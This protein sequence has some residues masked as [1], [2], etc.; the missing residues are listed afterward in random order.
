MG[1]YLEQATLLE[2]E[3]FIKRVKIAVKQIAT[4]VSG[5]A[6]NDQKESLYDKR[7]KLAYQVLNGNMT[8]VFAENLVSYNANVSIDSTDQYLADNI[9]AIFNAI[10]GV[11]ITEQ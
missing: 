8:T 6:F 3:D 10:A 1:N 5:E 4:F 2:S 11:K 7:H 9:S